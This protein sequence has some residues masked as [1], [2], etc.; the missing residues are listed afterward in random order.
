MAPLSNA[1]ACVSPFT[2]SQKTIDALERLRKSY[3]G[4][5]AQAALTEVDQAVLMAVELTL[6]H[7]RKAK[8]LA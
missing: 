3:E 2:M 5:F 7:V 8:L 4:R 1:S 6:K